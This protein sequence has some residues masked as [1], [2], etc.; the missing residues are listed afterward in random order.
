M[1]IALGILILVVVVLLMKYINLKTENKFLGKKKN[2]AETMLS[3][4]F[5]QLI[6]YRDIIIKNN[7]E[8]PNYNQMMTN[9][10]NSPF[11]V[12]SILDEIAEKG[13]DNVSQDK[14]DFLKNNTDG[15]N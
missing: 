2:E 10:I 13:I 3:I 15:K 12:D 14:L 7:L 9:N 6:Q 8:V 1:N 11:T 5:N 4:Y